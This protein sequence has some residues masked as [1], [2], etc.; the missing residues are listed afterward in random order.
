MPTPR[1]APTRWASSR[2]ATLQ[3]RRVCLNN[4]SIRNSPNP[5]RRRRRTPSGAVQGAEVGEFL[6]A[7]WRAMT[8]PVRLEAADGMFRDP[9][10]PRVLLAAIKENVVQPW[11]LAFRHKR[12]LLDE[13][14]PR[15]AGECAG[16]P[17][18]TRRGPRKG[19]EAVRI[20]VADER[21][22]AQRPRGVRAR[23]RASATSSTDWATRSGP[24]WRLSATGPRNSFCRTSSC[25]ISPSRKTTSLT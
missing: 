25:R 13:P 24:T 3:G 10:R 4:W 18:R 2:W 6:V 23:L 8:P 11:T 7:H 14:R 19:A 5:S 15:A 17:G 21:R 22:P 9:D 20:G 1:C 16:A 12:Q